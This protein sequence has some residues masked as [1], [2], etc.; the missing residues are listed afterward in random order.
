MKFYSAVEIERDE[1]GRAC[2]SM[3]EGID[4]ARIDVETSDKQ[5]TGRR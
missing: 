1:G 4:S 5:A 3:G 2:G